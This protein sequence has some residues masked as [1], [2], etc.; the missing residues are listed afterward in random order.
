MY[1]CHRRAVTDRA[2]R[3]AMVGGASNPAEVSRRCGAGTGCGGCLPALRM[4]LA[5]LGLCSGGDQAVV[6]DHAA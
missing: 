4:L 5:E 3:A 6:D 2:V 1:V